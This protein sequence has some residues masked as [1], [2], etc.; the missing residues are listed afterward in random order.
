MNK[1]KPA[2]GN[3]CHHMVTSSKIS[4]SSQQHHKPTA[5]HTDNQ[6]VIS[7]FSFSLGSIFPIAPRP[8]LEYALIFA[9][10]SITLNRSIC[11]NTTQ[12]HTTWYQLLHNIIYCGPIKTN[13]LLLMQP[14]CL[15]PTN[16]HNFW[17]IYTIVNL[18]LETI[19]LAHND[20][21]CLAVIFYYVADSAAVTPH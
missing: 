6:E 3:Y 17:H 13:P 5:R 16:F 15:L 19:K 21:V 9:S 11:W 20:T 18:Q 10:R 1:A 4:A 14:L 7:S 12:S 2:T 8:S